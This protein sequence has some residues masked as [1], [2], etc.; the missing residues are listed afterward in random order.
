VEPASLPLRRPA[1][2]TLVPPAGARRENVGLYRL[3]GTRW[4]WV[5]AA[6][7]SATTAFRGESRHLGSFGLFRDDIAPRITL[8]SSPV[9][10]AAKAPY[11]RWAIEASVSDGESGIDGEQSF[12]E[13]DGQRVPTEWDPEAGVL[14]WRPLRAPVQAAH[15][16]AVVVADRAGNV[17]HEAGTVRR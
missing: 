15:E 14:R 8:R 5:G 13:V 11:S 4:Q 7:D 17:S 1:R 9:R 2:F 3:D 10:S 6:V 12:L 16:V